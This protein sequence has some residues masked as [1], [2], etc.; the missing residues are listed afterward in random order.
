MRLVSSLS[1]IKAACT[2]KY[3]FQD[4]LAKKDAST[5]SG[6]SVLYKLD[7]FWLRGMSTSKGVIIAFR[8]MRCFI[9]HYRTVWEKSGGGSEKA[10]SSFSPWL[11]KYS[12]R[13]KP[14]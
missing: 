10:T 8:L 1:E 4:C 6:I 13:R 7:D 14:N 5:F 2:S 3:D 11:R 9:F 12:S